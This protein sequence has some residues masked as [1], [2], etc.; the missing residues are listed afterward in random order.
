MNAN[1]TY[2]TMYANHTDER[3][4]ALEVVSESSCRVLFEDG[5]VEIVPLSC[6]TLDD[7][8]TI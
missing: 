3:C 7:G 4:E 5:A 6:I 1:A 8:V 2:R